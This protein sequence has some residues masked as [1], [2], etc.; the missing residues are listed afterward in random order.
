MDPLY[1]I[2][3]GII[4][5]GILIGLVFSLRM[6]RRIKS[7]REEFDRQMQDIIDRNTR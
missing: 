4:V 7:H 5:A 1:W 3:L 2:I 6:D